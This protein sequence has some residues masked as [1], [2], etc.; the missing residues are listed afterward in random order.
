[1]SDCIGEK[2]W[3]NYLSLRAASNES[4]NK[5]DRQKIEI[6]IYLVTAVSKHWITGLPD[7]N[8]IKSEF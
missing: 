6:L 1:M 2:F 3:I 8:E 4:P 5:Y 7:I